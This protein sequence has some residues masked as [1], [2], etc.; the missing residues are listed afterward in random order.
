MA[1]KINILVEDLTRM[2]PMIRSQWAFIRGI[3]ARS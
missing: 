3:A 1:D 2:L